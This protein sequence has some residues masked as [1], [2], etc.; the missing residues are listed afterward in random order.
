MGRSERRGSIDWSW[1]AKKRAC[2]R[3]WPWPSGGRCGLCQQSVVAMFTLLC[4]FSH[5]PSLR[6][7]RLLTCRP[8][9]GFASRKI[10]QGPA[11]H[12]GLRDDDGGDGREDEGDVLVQLLPCCTETLAGCVHSVSRPASFHPVALRP[13]CADFRIHEACSTWLAGRTTRAT[14]SGDSPCNVGNSMTNPDACLIWW[15]A[16]R[17]SVDMVLIL[18]P[19]SDFFHFDSR[20]Q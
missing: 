2:A 18:A 10:V 12:S 11:I 17:V 3:S 5:Q 20:W 15:R 6:H 9:M 8:M 13:R 4:L 19:V 7:V 1:N 14:H 16:R